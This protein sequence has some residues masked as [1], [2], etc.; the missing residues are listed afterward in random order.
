MRDTKLGHG[1]TYEEK[2]KLKQLLL[3]LAGF[4]IVVYCSGIS[5]LY[6]SQVVHYNPKIAV[7]VAEDQLGVLENKLKA[8]SE[9][10]LE[11]LIETDLLVKCRNYLPRY[12]NQK[13]TATK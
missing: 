5:Y 7:E 13:K 2:S 4:V 3:K 1:C 11:I 6:F 9:K 10:Y 12:Q 8:L